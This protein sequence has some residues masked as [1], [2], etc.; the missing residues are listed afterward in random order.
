MSVG[1]A[2]GATPPNKMDRDCLAG[3]G[4]GLVGIKQQGYPCP[5]SVPT[6]AA[7]RMNRATATL[8][9]EAHFLRVSS[10]YCAVTVPAPDTTYSKRHQM[11]LGVETKP[12]ASRPNGTLMCDKVSRKHSR[13]DKREGYQLMSELF[14]T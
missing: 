11:A 1:N 6:R 12:E 5:S 8:I 3:G 9:Q 13:K 2:T 14:G 10:D 4:A 7:A